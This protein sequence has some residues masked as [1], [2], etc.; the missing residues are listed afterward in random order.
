MLKG[1]R[2]NNVEKY[3]EELKKKSAKYNCLNLF[4]SFIWHLDNL[5]NS[6]TITYIKVICTVSVAI[7]I[8]VVYIIIYEYGNK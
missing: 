6:H 5:N 2:T 7:C 4:L 3:T 8:V 1:H